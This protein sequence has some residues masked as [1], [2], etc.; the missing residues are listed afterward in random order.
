MLVFGSQTGKEWSSQGCQGAD[1]SSR[2]LGRSQNSIGS[3]WWLIACRPAHPSSWSII[4]ITVYKIQVL[5]DRSLLCTCNSKDKHIRPEYLSNSTTDI[6]R[7]LHSLCLWE[8]DCLQTLMNMSCCIHTVG[9]K[10]KPTPIKDHWVLYTN[11]L[12][13]KQH[14]EIDPQMWS[15][16]FRHDTE[17]IWIEWKFLDFYLQIL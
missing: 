17:M 6:W 16:D 7:W 15:A 8:P 11:Q 4:S 9:H 2:V 14:V 1:K 5:I 13:R 3:S 10:K 12:D